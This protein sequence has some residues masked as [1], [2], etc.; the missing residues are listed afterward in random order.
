MSG[1]AFKPSRYWWQVKW[2]GN[3]QSESISRLI[4][5][6]IQGKLSATNFHRSVPTNLA[7]RSPFL[8]PVSNMRVPNMFSQVLTYTH[9]N[10]T[11]SC[12]ILLLTPNSEKLAFIFR[13]CLPFL[14]CTAPAAARPDAP[15][16]ASSCGSSDC[17]CWWWQNH[18]YSTWEMEEDLK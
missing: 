6:N 11:S 7:I 1:C 18:S 9:V 4:I 15:E 13:L 3:Q 8:K 12:Q 14:T 16:G 10:S 17:S 2:S 5:F